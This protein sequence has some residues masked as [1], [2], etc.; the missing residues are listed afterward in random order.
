MPIEHPKDDW[1][2]TRLIRKFAEER[3]ERPFLQYEDGDAYSFAD[4]ER[5]SNQYGHTFQREGVAFGDNVAVM[6]HNRLEYL[7]TWFGLNR[8]GAVPVAI[9]T[10]YKGT[11]LTHVL[12]NVEARIAVVEPE[13]LPWLADIE[14]TVPEL[15][16]IFV[17]AESLAEVDIP[18]FARLEVRSFDELRDGPTDPLP[19]TVTYRDIGMIMFTSGTTGPSKGVL[20][21]HGHLY[22]FGLSMASHMQLDENDRYYICM[23]LFHAQG[24][25]MQFYASLLGGGY[26]VLVKQFRATSWM[27]EVRQYGATVTNTLGVMSDFVLRQP[28]H[29]EDRNNNLRLLCAVPVVEETLQAFRDR[30]GIPQFNEVFGMTECNIPVCRPA[31]APDEAGCSG[32]VWDE[33]FEVIVADPD[34]DEPLPVGEVGEILVR[35]KEPFCFMQGY[36]GMPDRTVETWRNFWFHTGDAGRLDERGYLW[37]IDR[38]KDTIR[39]RGE[40]ISSY[41][42]EAVILDFP[43]VAEAAAVAV[44]ADEGGEDEVLVCMIAEEPGAEPDPVEILDYC[45]PRMPYFAVPRYLEF[46]D[47]IPKTPSQ[48]IQKNRLRERGLSNRTWDREAVGYKVKRG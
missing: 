39:R 1:V 15:Q 18:A 40:N 47:D 36:N 21:P 42:V 34:T 32:K 17:V 12:T 3:G 29:P 7:W 35:P 11:F 2:I 30:F 43:G 19:L 46:V 9:N 31:D 8:L 27:A 20:M 16:T 5:L 38:I 23:P 13:F 4:L 6:L 10:A 41:E 45:V 28:P 37:Y 24:S 22:L 33:Y 14:H 25:L 44:R 26:A 48:K